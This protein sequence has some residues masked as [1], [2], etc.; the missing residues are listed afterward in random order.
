MSSEKR[1]PDEIFEE[2]SGLT[3]KN[4]KLEDNISQK[5]FDKKYSL[6]VLNKLRIKNAA[7][8]FFSS[9]IE[10]I[11]QLFQ[12]KN[13]LQVN[14]QKDIEPDDNIPENLL[15]ENAKESFS[16]LKIFKWIKSLIKPIRIVFR[17]IINL[18]KLFIKTF[19]LIIKLIIR[20]V[21]SYF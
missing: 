10:K 16:L 1:I 4:G 12:T 2:L 14:R 5:E 7:E 17:A 20:I 21:R 11:Y 3:D 13:L 6:N 19:T 9:S 8:A 15:E 18:S